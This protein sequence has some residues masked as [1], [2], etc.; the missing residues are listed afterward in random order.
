VV[1]DPTR[2][3][4]QTDDADVAPGGLAAPGDEGVEG[5]A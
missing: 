4:A 5:A 1:A 3:G 2:R